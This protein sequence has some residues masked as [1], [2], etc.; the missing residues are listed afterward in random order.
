MQ[1]SFEPRQMPSM[2]RK[3]FSANISG[4]NPS[5]CTQRLTHPLH[6][7]CGWGQLIRVTNWCVSE[8]DG[9]ENHPLV[10]SGHTDPRDSKRCVL[11]WLHSVAALKTGPSKASVSP[12]P[13]HQQQPE[14]MEYFILKPT[15]LPNS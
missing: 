14:E 13:P 10:T 15:S 2:R 7:D 6:L 1:L 8:T 5:R 11:P 12:D 9:G 4:N 3:Q